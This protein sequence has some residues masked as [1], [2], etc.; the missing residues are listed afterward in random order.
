[1][2]NWS[3]ISEFIGSKSKLQCEAHYY[4]FY[5]NSESGIP[6]ETDM[7]LKKNNEI[8]K[9]KDSENQ[10]KYQNILAEIKHKQGVIQESN[11]KDGRFN[12]SRSIIKNRNRKDQNANINTTANEIVGYWP[13][14]EDFDIEY[15]NDAELEIAEIEF[16]DDIT[17]SEK[18]LKLNMLRVY[19]NEL[20]ERERRK[21]QVYIIT[22]SFRFVIE[23]NLLDL[24]RHINFERKLPKD[25]RDIYTCLKPFARFLTKDQFT[26]FYEGLILEKNL[27][28]RLN[29][30][31]S[32]K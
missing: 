1:M 27:K 8:D 21:K 7:I 3:D 32:Y 11:N 20:L 23:N 10:E 26:E 28:L 25:D 16:Q 9:N 4:S 17:Q 31:R 19:N 12:S 5:L 13:K 29:Q 2:D 18:D 14:R 22:Y 15:L 6:L 30:L 24:K